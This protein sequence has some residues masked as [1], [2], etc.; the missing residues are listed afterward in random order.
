MAW[1]I[2][3]LFL[4]NIDKYVYKL[5]DLSVMQI[6]IIKSVTDIRRDAKRIFEQVHKKGE[7]ILV[8]RNNDKL[9][10]IVPPEAY[11]SMMT[12][13]ETLWE[14]LEMA[15]SKK[16]TRGEKSFKLRDVLSGKV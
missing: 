13:N 6:P 7:V 15:R 12:E 1:Q 2:S 10:V 11:E 4:S 9:S 5:Y 8:T 16:A 3:L 14:E